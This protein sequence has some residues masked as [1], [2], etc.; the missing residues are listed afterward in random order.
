MEWGLIF[1]IKN[2]SK[3]SIVIKYF[4]I[5]IE[6]GKCFGSSCFRLCLLLSLTQVQTIVASIALFELFLA[7]KHTSKEKSIT[8]CRG[9]N[10]SVP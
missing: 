1:K 2:N 9:S 3:K 5:L 7:N 4:S 10:S 8:K 6:H